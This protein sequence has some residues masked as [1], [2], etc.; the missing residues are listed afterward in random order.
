MSNFEVIEEVVY[1]SGEDETEVLV[2]VFSVLRVC[3]FR[4]KKPKRRKSPEKSGLFGY[5]A[6]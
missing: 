5:D 3:F 2:L 6:K 1:L 4:V